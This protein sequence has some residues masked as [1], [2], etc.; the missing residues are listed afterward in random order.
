MNLFQVIWAEL[1][2]VA[3]TF[4]VNRHEFGLRRAVSTARYAVVGIFAH[5]QEGTTGCLCGWQ[6]WPGLELEQEA[7]LLGHLEICP[8][9]IAHRKKTGCDL[10][11]HKHD[12]T[13]V[14]G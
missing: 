11:G 13:E 5:H 14:Q 8:E 4:G 2:N 12:R 10:R 9:A 3:Y 1:K 7:Q 6:C